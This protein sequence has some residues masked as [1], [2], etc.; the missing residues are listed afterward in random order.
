MGTIFLVLKQLGLKNNHSLPP[1]AEVKMTRA[2]HPMPLYSFLM[3]K[4][5]TLPSLPQVKHNFVTHYKLHTSK[6]I[7]A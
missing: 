4:G 3:D 7:T 5:T 2:I 1:N 6:A